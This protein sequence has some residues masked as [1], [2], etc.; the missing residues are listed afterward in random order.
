M[1]EIGKMKPGEHQRRQERREQRE[2]KRDLLRVGD[3]RDE[4][5]EAR[6]RRPG[7]ATR[8]RASTTHEPRI[9]MSNSTIAATTMLIDEIERDDE[10]R[11]RLAEHVR[12][13][14]DRRHPHLL[15]RPGFLL[16]HDRQRRGDDGGEHRDVGDEAGDEEQRAAQLG[17]VPDARLDVA[18]SAPSCEPMRACSSYRCDWRVDQAHRVAHDRRRGVGVVAV[19]EE[20]H[21]RVGRP[22]ATSAPKRAGITSTAR[23]SP[24]IEQRVD[25]ARAIH[26]AD[27]IEVAGVDEAEIS[28]RLTAL[29][30]LS[31]TASRTWRMSKFS[32]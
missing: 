5:A 13:R 24:S 10:V 11:R 23:A 2:L 16:A 27:E 28:S 9:G 4:Q 3:A 18:A 30:S 19:D 17:V 20:L 7:T 12:H 26:L 22:D 31:W 14:P 29:R 32:A 15:H 25:L 8:C 21:R 1:L 6:A